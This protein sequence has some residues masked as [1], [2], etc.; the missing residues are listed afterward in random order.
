MNN[1]VIELYRRVYR[2]ELLDELRLSLS[3]SGLNVNVAENVL[4]RWLMNQTDLGNTTIDPVFPS[5]DQGI[6]DEELMGFLTIKGMSEVDVGRLH[7]RLLSKSQTIAELLSSEVESSQGES[8]A[9][10]VSHRG[11]FTTTLRLNRVVHMDHRGM[12]T[13]E[14]GNGYYDRLSRDADDR[15]IYSMITRYRT[16]GGDNYQSA[17]LDKVFEVLRNRLGITHEAFASPINRNMDMTFTSLYP[18]VDRHY[19][20]LGTYRDLPEILSG[21][22]GYVGVQANP[23]FMES[24]MTRLSDLTIDILGTRQDPTLFAIVVPAWPD[25]KCH[26]R[27]TESSYTRR[28]LDLPRYQHG[29]VVGSH[30]HT[31]STKHIS[32]CDST[33]FILSNRVLGTVDIPVGIS[34]AE[35]AIRDA[36][37]QSSSRRR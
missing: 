16:L 13:V 20:S 37:G 25:S 34:E 33:M 12:L 15:L 7:D 32:L 24:V 29:Y 11:R 3:R 9:V 27:L 4:S 35:V 1:P 21:M 18:D 10:V 17:I 28:I 31:P 5:Q 23:P 26:R 2:S 36:F 6:V 14:I 19:D 22:D 8:E 30:Y